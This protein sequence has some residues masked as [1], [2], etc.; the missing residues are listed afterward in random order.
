MLVA[1]ASLKSL[2][3][4]LIFPSQTHGVSIHKSVYKIV[5][6][7]LSFFEAKR[8]EKCFDNE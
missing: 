2:L 5:A 1:F 7:I 3:V 6:K 8:L 4:K